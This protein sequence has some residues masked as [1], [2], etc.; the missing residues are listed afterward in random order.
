MYIIYADAIVSYLFK[1][2][3]PSIAYTGTSGGAPIISLVVA[4]TS[5]DEKRQTTDVAELCNV[6]V[7]YNSSADGTNNV[8]VDVLISNPFD[9]D[10]GDG[11]KRS[12]LLPDVPM[13]VVR[14]LELLF[15]ILVMD[16]DEVVG[17]GPV[18]P[19]M[20]KVDTG[21][22]TITPFT[23]NRIDALTITP[24]HVSKALSS[25]KQTRHPTV[26]PIPYSNL[27]GSAGENH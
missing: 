22:E 1:I 3:L 23:F 9:D 4:I 21:G 17:R 2:T 11:D 6:T 20:G 16:V 26:E 8:N 18:T 24:S 13:V 27:D 12:L 5:S 19:V 10:I 25:S 7:G 14:P 15:G